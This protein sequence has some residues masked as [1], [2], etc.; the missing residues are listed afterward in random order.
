MSNNIR[1]LSVFLLWEN[2]LKQAEATMETDFPL[3]VLLA[4]N[5]MSRT[6]IEQ[7]SRTDSRTDSYDI[8]L[9]GQETQN[10]SAVVVQSSNNSPNFLLLG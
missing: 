10:L 7:I 8:L 3:V 6:W 9:L 1:A 2:L 5:D 4:K